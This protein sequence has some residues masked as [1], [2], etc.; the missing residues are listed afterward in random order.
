MPRS[1]GVRESAAA[2]HAKTHYIGLGLTRSIKLAWQEHIRQCPPSMWS[3]RKNPPDPETPP[4]T[5]YW[6]SS[7]FDWGEAADEY[8]LE[9]DERM[10]R[11]RR[12]EFDEM[13]DRYARVARSVMGIAAER[14]LKMSMDGEDIRIQDIP[15][16]V[17]L[18]HD[19]ESTA[20][21]VGIRETTDRIG[22]SGPLG[23]PVP[24]EFRLVMSDSAMT[25]AQPGDESRVT[26]TKE[27]DFIDVQEPPAGA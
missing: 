13:L 3:Q 2:R 9:Q 11:R 1:K 7:K 5:W 22:A 24:V 18:A 21:G 27:D 15:A 12:T 10:L 17:R 8:D 14:M 25:Q 23:G 16:W 26:D 6:W 19:I 4:G 20:L